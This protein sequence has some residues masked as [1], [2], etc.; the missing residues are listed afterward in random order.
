MR[1]LTESDLQAAERTFRLAFGTFLGLP[2]PMTFSGDASYIRT[3]WLEDPSAAFCAEANGELV[4]SN[5]ATNWGSVGFF[6]PLTVNPAFWGSGAGKRL[7]E[8]IME[9]FEH[10]QTRHAGLYT[11]AQSPK[12]VAL[13]QK[14]GFAPRFLTALMSKPV[15]RTDCG[16]DWSTFSALAAN[17]QE[18]SLVA[19]REITDAVYAG[20]DVSREILAVA[21]HGFGETILLREDSALEAFAVCHCGPGTEVGS[22]ACY[23]KFAAVRPGPHAGQTFDRLLSAGEEMA[24]GRGLTRLVA[25]VNTAR[26]EAYRQMAARGFRTQNQGVAMHRPNEPGYNRSGVYVLDDWR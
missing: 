5:F 24:R 2:D 19:C 15:E 23:V 6:G 1:Q 25:G 11:F 21:T 17:E 12:H 7:M 22:G 18:A 8:P 16:A 10:W 20:L 13:Y 3:R 4:G 26:E 14:F 9:S